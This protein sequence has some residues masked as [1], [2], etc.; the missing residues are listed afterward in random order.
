[1]PGRDVCRQRIMATP[2]AMRMTRRW[3]WTTAPGLRLAA[4]MHRAK[5]YIMSR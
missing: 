2:A 4:V 3:A 1:M 5:G